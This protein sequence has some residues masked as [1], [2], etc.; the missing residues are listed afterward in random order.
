M[1]DDR[2]SSERQESRNMNSTFI[3]RLVW[4][5]EARLWRIVLK[6][7]AGGPSQVFADLE[8]AFLYIARFYTDHD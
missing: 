6:P 7:A 2:Q 3:L 4:D 5:G 8:M 1:Q